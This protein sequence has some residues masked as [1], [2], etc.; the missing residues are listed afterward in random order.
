[1][2][3]LCIV[4]LYLFSV[5]NLTSAFGQD[6]TDEQVWKAL[7]TVKYKIT[8]DEYGELYVPEFSEDAQKMEGKIVTVPGYIIPFDGLF[9]PEHVIVSSLPLASCF[10]CGSGGPETVMEVFLTKPISYTESMVAFRGKL[11]LNDENYEE[12]MYILEDAE[13]VGPVGN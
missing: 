8:E 5:A 13:L 4:A 2:K 11:K 7:S 6:N 1:M 9:K 3:L 10:F 12:L